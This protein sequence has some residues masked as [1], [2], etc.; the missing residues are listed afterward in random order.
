T[1]LVLPDG[2]LFEKEAAVLNQFFANS[3]GRPLQQ[4]TAA[5]HSPKQA[6]GTASLPKQVA[7]PTFI[8]LV[9]DPAITA[10]EGY[11]IVITRRQVLLSAR[12]AAGMFMAVQTIR[13]LLP[14]GIESPAAQ[15]APGAYPAVK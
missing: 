1:R 6:P 13:Q 3:F 2:R 7:G 4:S 12:T 14:A 9:Y 5:G 15:P 8:E 10:E 11:G